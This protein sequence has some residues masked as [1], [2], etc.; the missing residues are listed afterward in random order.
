MGLLG[1][2]RMEVNRNVDKPSNF[3]PIDVTY[4]YMEDA[5]KRLLTLPENALDSIPVFL[6]C[7][8]QIAAMQRRVHADDAIQALPHG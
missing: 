3:G 5:W 8:Y 6:T 1:K 2:L 4:P 7:Y